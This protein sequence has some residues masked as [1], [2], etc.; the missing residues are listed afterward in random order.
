MKAIN[1][2][3]EAKRNAHVGIQPMNGSIATKTVHAGGKQHEN[4][5]LLKVTLNTT[6]D[7]LQA[8][9]GEDLTDTII[10]SDAETDME[11]VGL[12]LQ[13]TKKV[14][15]DSDGRIAHR[16]SFREVVFNVDGTQ[17]EERK[18][19]DLDANINI[20]LPVRWT[21]KL[22]PT[23]KAVKM[24]VFAQTHQLKHVDGLTYD[25]LYEM[26][27][28]LYEKKAMMLLGGG[29]KG[30]GPLVLSRGAT[31]YRA[32]LSGRIDGDKYCLLLHLTNLELKQI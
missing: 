17:K 2:S 27:K 5:R 7:A 18:P 23:A 29:L 14:Y 32:F 26:A 10:N 30:V 31:P 4:V 16:V 19:E 6:P 20:D 12:R 13:K 24:F 21:G 9:Y 22:I 1:L 11:R 3:N 25:F 8:K 15:I 28:T